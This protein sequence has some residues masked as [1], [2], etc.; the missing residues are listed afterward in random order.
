MIYYISGSRQ[1]FRT[2]CEK[3][4]LR[5]GTEILFANERHYLKGLNPINDKIVLGPAW[6]VRKWVR[7]VLND[8]EQMN[9]PM[10]IT[11]EDGYF[12]KEARDKF[13]EVEQ[14]EEQLQSERFNNRF[15]LF[16]L[17]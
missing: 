14:Q 1:S 11:Y 10:P 13:E 4:S 5:M 8:L 3:H 15:E 6:W 7:P 16:E 2:H 17:D 9:P 12:G